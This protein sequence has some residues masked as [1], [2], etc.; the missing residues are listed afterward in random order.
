MPA[1]VE[2]E[3][4]VLTHEHRNPARQAQSPADGARALAILLVLTAF[5]LAPFIA[6]AA[7]TQNAA[8]PQVAQVISSPSKTNK[9]CPK[10]S[11]PGQSNACTSSSVPAAGLDGP[12]GAPAPVV[13][14]SSIAPLYDVALTTQCCGAPPDRPPRFAA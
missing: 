6:A 2:D 13:Q 14:R 3:L 5:L 11:L 10:K 7:K 12:G 8:T 1:I 9:S 4:M